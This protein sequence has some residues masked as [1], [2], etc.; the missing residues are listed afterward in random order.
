[1]VLG[2]GI[3]TTTDGEY[4]TAT[5]GASLTKV[6]RSIDL[7]WT[8]KGQEIEVTALFAAGAAVLLLLAVGWSVLRTGRVI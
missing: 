2:F 8:V 5:D 6:Y 3:A 1:M 7:S 4:L